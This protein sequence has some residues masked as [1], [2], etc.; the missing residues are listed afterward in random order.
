[1]SGSQQ[2]RWR[3]I[4]KK[5]PSLSTPEQQKLKR[6][7]TRWS[8]VAPELRA[9]ARKKYKTYK[10]KKPEEQDRLRSAWQ[11]H[12]Q[13]KGQDESILLPDANQPRPEDPSAANAATNAIPMP[14][15]DSDQTPLAPGTESQD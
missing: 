12:Q 9:G 15:A 4:A 2:E 1:M 5:Y 10:K 8:S 3:G 14:Q 13:D 11:N 6:R 7:M